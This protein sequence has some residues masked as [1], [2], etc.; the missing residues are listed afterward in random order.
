M[1]SQCDSMQVGV[2]ELHQRRN[3]QRH[4]ARVEAVHNSW[5]IKLRWLENPHLYE[6]VTM[7]ELQSQFHR[8]RN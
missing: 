3:D 1:I 8:V 6:F 5:A 4:T 7:S 2:G